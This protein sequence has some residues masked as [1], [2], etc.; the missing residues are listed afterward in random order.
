M[1]YLVQFVY[2]QLLDL[3][4]TIAFLLNGIHEGNPLVRWALNAAP[5]PWGG[6]LGVKVL[7]VLL[8][9]YC[10]RLGKQRLLARVNFLFAILV[11]WNLVALI[12]GSVLAAK[13]I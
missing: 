12:A 13:S 11:A 7:A 1:N 8:G 3:L 10:W 9:L 5:T 6:L 4:T 2:L